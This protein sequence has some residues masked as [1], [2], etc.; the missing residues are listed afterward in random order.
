MLADADQQRQAFLVHIRDER[1]LATRTVE[2]YQRELDQLDAWLKES[3]DS[4]QSWNEISPNHVRQYAAAIHRRGRSG[5]SIAAALS[6]IRTFYRFLLRE[7]WATNNPAEGVA[8][9]KNANK[10]PRVLDADQA[11]ALL[12]FQP[13]D[14]LETR[15]KAIFELA[16]SSGLRV[17]ELASARLEDFDFSEGLVRVLGKG[18]SERLVPV[19]QQAI[20]AIRHWQRE[21]EQLVPANSDEG[22][23]FTNR[24]GG[25]LST[26]GIRSRLTRLTRKLGLNTHVSPH[27][28]RHSVATQLISSS[29]DLRAV[30]EL[31]GHK[32][33]ST[34]QVYTHL[35]FGHLAKLY[36]ECHPRAGKRRKD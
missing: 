14:A 3:P 27:M 22:W 36:D 4:P 8:A 32:N 12:D 13:E 7:A 30:Q 34:T 18:N 33:L 29:G 21:R 26:A 16:Y 23:L 1:R 19:G 25:P 5:R 31:L 9:P 10:L 35:D 20:R 2:N 11:N 15:D 24:S 6:A 28:L 17:S